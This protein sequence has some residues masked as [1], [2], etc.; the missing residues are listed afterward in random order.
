MPVPRAP[1]RE[2]SPSAA[3]GDEA[4]AH[5]TRTARPRTPDDRTPERGA[6]P[7]DDQAPGP[8]PAD[9]A[10]SS[11][12]DRPARAAAEPPQAAVPADVGTSRVH[13]THGLRTTVPAHPSHVPGVR[14]LVAEHLALLRLPAH[15]LDDAVLAAKELFTNAL[16]HGSPERG[17]TITVGIECGPYELRVSVADRSPALPARRTADGPEESGRG[18][19]IVAALTDDWGVAAADPGTTGKKVWFSMLLRGLR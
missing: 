9:P 2:P 12:P 19:T 16:R 8:R 7:A 13:G 3:P 11:A 4:P 15:R 6:H 1:R 18:L 5:E 14:A 10:E 17:D